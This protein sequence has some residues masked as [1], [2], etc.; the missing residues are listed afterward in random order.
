MEVVESDVIR[1]IE[2]LRAECVQC[3]K[4][5]LADTRRSVA[6]G[7]GNPESPLMIVGE[8]PVRTRTRPAGRSWAGRECY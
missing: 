8:G 7:E 4:C 2:E 5:G 1:Q 6:F 3:T